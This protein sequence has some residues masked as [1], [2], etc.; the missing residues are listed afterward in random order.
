M[1]DGSRPWGQE[2]RE[3]GLWATCW[4]D[5]VGG[6][7]PALG[8]SCSWVQHHI[9][10]QSRPSTSILAGQCHGDLTS[11]APKT[12]PGDANLSI[13]PYPLRMEITVQPCLPLQPHIHSLAP[14]L[15]HTLEDGHSEA[16]CPGHPGNPQWTGPWP[17]AGSGPGA[18]RGQQPGPGRLDS[19][20]PGAS[21][22]RHV[23]WPLDCWQLVV[24]S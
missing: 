15:T 18:G 14:I 12:Q 2:R 16:G 8:T 7:W 3:P 9:P 4:I 24:R 6:N 19:V 23:C 10:G 13:T 17:G 11:W 20:L 1:K 5:S 21:V 22:S